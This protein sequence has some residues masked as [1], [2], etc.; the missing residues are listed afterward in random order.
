MTAEKAANG[1]TP[2]VRSAGG[3]RCRGGNSGV[4]CLRRATPFA[5]PD[6]EVHDGNTGDCGN[7]RRLLHVVRNCPRQRRVPVSGVSTCAEHARGDE[8]GEEGRGSLWGGQDTRCH[9]PTGAAQE[10]ALVRALIRL[11]DGRPSLPGRLADG[12]RFS[13]SSLPGITAGDDSV[14]D[15]TKDGVHNYCPVWTSIHNNQKV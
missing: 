14:E 1:P 5:R 12:G 9:K 13:S 7:G 4:E 15:G 6:V 10:S 11:A 3:G 2:P 8:L